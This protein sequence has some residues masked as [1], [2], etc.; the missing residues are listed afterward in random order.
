MPSAIET[1][2]ST[3]VSDQTKLLLCKVITTANNRSA[4]NTEIATEKWQTAKQK[5]VVCVK[6][7]RM[8][9]HTAYHTTC[10]LPIILGE[11]PGT[12]KKKKKQAG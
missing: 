10:S 7:E 12:H 1:S 5:R 2:R 11:D 6:N 9:K 8:T 4:P 3:H